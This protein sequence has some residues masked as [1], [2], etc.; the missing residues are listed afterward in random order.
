MRGPL[1]VGPRPAQPVD[2]LAVGT[3]GEALLGEGGAQAVAAKALQRLA[4]IR[5]YKLRGV[6]GEPRDRGAERLALNADLFS[7]RCLH[8]RQ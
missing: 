6:Q 3:P 7:T 8:P 1:R 5:L 4:V 2:N